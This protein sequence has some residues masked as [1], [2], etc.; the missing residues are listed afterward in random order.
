MPIKMM[1]ESHLSWIIGH[2]ACKWVF[3]SLKKQDYIDLEGSINFSRVD[4]NYMSDHYHLEKIIARSY[5]TGLLNTF[6]TYCDRC[7]N[8]MK[9]IIDNDE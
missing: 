6:E 8:S 4:Y 2:I 3:I 5:D 7:R 9:Y 1:D